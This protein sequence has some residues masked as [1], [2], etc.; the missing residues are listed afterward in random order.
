MLI[1]L[2][3]VYSSAPASFNLVATSLFLFFFLCYLQI[4]SLGRDAGRWYNNK[5]VIPSIMLIT[6]NLAQTLSFHMT[7]EVILHHWF[8][9]TCPFSKLNAGQFTFS[10]N[11][12]WPCCIRSFTHT[13][14]ALRERSF[15]ILPTHR[16]LSP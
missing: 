2:G 6:F 11:L 1:G 5:K 15:D 12:T 16:T 3:T 8:V 13:T 7:E 10:L 9:H 14:K 4:S